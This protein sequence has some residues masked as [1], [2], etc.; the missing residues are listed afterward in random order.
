MSLILKWIWVRFRD[1]DAVLSQSAPCAS[2]PN[3]LTASRLTA[4]ASGFLNLSQ[5][6]ERPE[7][8]RSSPSA[9]RRSPPVPLASV[10]EHDVALVTLEI[11]VE[12]HAVA[13]LAQDARRRCLAH[14]KRPAGAGARVGRAD[15]NNVWRKT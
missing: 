4:G 9:S 5:S 3:P 2:R 15:L 8:L 13:A 1:S 12:P 11:L 6:G 14:L 10:R 7:R